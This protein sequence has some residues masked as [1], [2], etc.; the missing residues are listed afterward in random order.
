MMM[1]NIIMNI[2][3]KSNDHTFRFRHLSKH[4][5]PQLKTKNPICLKF[6][7]V[8]L[9]RVESVFQ[10]FGKRAFQRQGAEDLKV[11]HSMTVKQG[12]RW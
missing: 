10:M 5:R 2:M 9:R 8:H 3:M 11:V 4:S 6:K 1:M 7:E 12:E